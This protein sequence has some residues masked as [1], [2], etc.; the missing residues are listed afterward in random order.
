MFGDANIQNLAPQIQNGMSLDRLNSY[1]LQHMNGIIDN[2]SC[3]YMT[4][5]QS[6]HFDKQCFTVLSFN[7]RCV[8]TNFTQFKAEMLTHAYDII[9]LCETKMTNEMEKLYMLPNYNFYLTNVASNKGGV[10]IYIKDTIA[11]KILP[12]LSIKSEHFESIFVEF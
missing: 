7:M 5:G 9:G 8:T 10:C 12:K 1:S 6:V 11:C 4:S 3:E 2:V